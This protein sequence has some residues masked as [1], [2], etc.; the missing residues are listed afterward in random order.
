[1][2]VPGQVQS[3][4][5]SGFNLKSLTPGA[6][7]SASSLRLENR[8][9]TEY[10]RWKNL[11]ESWRQVKRAGSPECTDG[12]LNTQFPESSTADKEFCMP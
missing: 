4:I 3:K 11:P 6:T 10:T 5:H 2:P 9:G 1:M 12:R 8:T 7:P